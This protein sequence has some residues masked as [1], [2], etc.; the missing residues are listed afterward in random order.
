MTETPSLHPHGS[1]H[2]NYSSITSFSIHQEQQGSGPLHDQAKKRVTRLVAILACAACV[3]SAILVGIK[4][5]ITKESSMELFGPLLGPYLDSDGSK[6]KKKALKA[7]LELA[8]D[9]EGDVIFANDASFC[10]AADV[11]QQGLD[12]PLAVVEVANEAD[13]QLAVPALADIY[14]ERGV[15]FRVRSGGHSYAG[16]STLAGGI[17]LSLSRLNNL[18]FD[19]STGIATV[20]PAVTVQDMLDGIL[21]PAG[22][23]GVVGECPGVAEGGFVLG[24]GFGFLSRKYGL[25]SDS[26]L[27]VRVVLTDGSVVV[28]SEHNEPD[29]FWAL[30]GAGQNTFGVVTQIQYQ[31][32]PSQD[33]QLL[34]SGDVPLDPS[35]MVAI[36]EKHAEAPG[37]FSFL[38]EGPISKDGTTD[39]LMGW[40]G[41]DDASLDSGEDY[42]NKDVI[43]LLS[44]NVRAGLSVD[45]ISWSS[46]TRESGNLDGNLVRAWTGFLYEEDNTEDVWDSIISKM[47]DVCVGN[48]YLI[49]D[50]ELWGG[51]I[52]DKKSDDTA[53]YYRKAI[54]NVGLVLLV[55]ADMNHAHKIFKDTV[56]DVDHV[57]WHIS[58]HLEGVYTNYVVESLGEKEYAR[59]YWGGNLDRLQDLKKKYDP[60]NI[61]HHPQSVPPPRN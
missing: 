44:K 37:E 35:F 3:T 45:R 55:P 16:F 19:E 14:L 49:V 52:S 53:F 15:P 38:L 11:W 29:L 31:L 6:A 28:A 57:W 59:A 50:I 5:D 22:Y 12:P 9:L 60:R 2:P 43:S 30:R 51:A 24:G 34:V 20:G 56:E 46:M 25:G 27:G 48:P 4:W 54:F 36:G 17:I 41:E 61:F 1:K 40:F 23:G 32:H 47:K 26:V 21:V 10:Q 39:A 8:D 13:V 33:T 7:L 42:I 58:K 18:N